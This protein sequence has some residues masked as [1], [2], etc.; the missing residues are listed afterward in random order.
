MIHLF[1]TN[2]IAMGRKL[3]LKLFKCNCY[4]FTS[5]NSHTY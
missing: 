2:E 1:S 4:C 3:R 5:I